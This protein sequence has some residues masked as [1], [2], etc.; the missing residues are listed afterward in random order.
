MK[1]ITL[2]SNFD[3]NL[4]NNAYKLWEQLH[5]VREYDRTKKFFCIVNTMIA[6]QSSQTSVSWKQ[7]KSLSNGDG[8]AAKTEIT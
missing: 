1:N 2:K 3:L 8:V 4:V 6:H 7:I 5:R